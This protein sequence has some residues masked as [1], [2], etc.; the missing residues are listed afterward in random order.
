MQGCV[1][2]A[3]GLV[4]IV[5][6]AAAV[7][8]WGPGLLSE[9]REPEAAETAAVQ[10]SPELARA[11]LDRLEAFREG[12]STEVRLGGAEVTS[13]L[14]Y[15]LPGMMPPGVSEPTA[16]MREGRLQLSARVA[17]EALP[18]IPS[19]NEVVGLLPDTVEVE[20]RGSLV[21]LGSERI[22]LHVESLEASRIPIPPR[23]TPAVLGALGR[24]DQPDLPQD[25]IAIPLPSGVRAVYVQQDSLVLVSDR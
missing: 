10:P 2:K 8:W 11:T 19:L 7:W 18:E 9:L 17:L 25:A 21:P 24:T 12:G 22:A 14:R 15:G 13:L 20:M 5:G 16:E 1:G 23:V 4:L 3:V 6:L